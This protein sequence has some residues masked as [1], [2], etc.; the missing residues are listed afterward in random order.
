MRGKLK[1]RRD[2]EPRHYV[3]KARL[4]N[5]PLEKNNSDSVVVFYIEYDEQSEP[6]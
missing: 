1:G 2:P 4:T 5:Y 3:Q 6:I